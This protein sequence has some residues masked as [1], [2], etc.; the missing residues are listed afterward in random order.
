[1]EDLSKSARALSGALEPVAG[2]VYF[3]PECHERYVQ[4]GFAPSSGEFGGVAAPDGPAYFTSR[5]SVMGQVPG[6]VVACAFGVF[7]PVA[8][9]AAVD[10]GW[11]LTDAATI[12]AAR[13]AG[14]IAQ[15][16]RVLGAEPD[17]VARANEL[18]A[19]AVEPLRP[20]GRP[21]YAGLASLDLPGSP[22]GDAWRRLDMLREFRG[23]SHINAWTTAGIDA[24]EMCLLTEPYWGLPLRSYSRTRAWSDAEFDAAEARLEAR[25]L[26]QGGTLTDRG[27]AEREAI[28]VAT[29]LQCRPFVDALGDDLDELVGILRPWA[30]AVQAAKGYPAAGPQDLAR[31]VDDR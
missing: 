3:S 25:G 12:C 16:E 27:R 18:L 21:L 26:L 10:F 4:L 19:R 30:A 29:D 15:L 17:G 5:G 9:K 31:G 11:T 2:Q 1:V 20:E 22:L 7:N 6:E 14:A 23:D 13:D 28:E 24:T 8:V